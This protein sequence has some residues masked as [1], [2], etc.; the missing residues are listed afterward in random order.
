MQPVNCML[1]DYMKQ[2]IEELATRGMDADI[3]ASIA[4]AEYAGLEY[5]QLTSATRN[6]LPD[7][8]FVFSKER[9][10]PIHD[11]AHAAN[12][13]A[14]AAGTK[15]HAAVMKAVCKKYPDMPAC[16][17][18]HDDSDAMWI[19]VFKTGTHTASNGTVKTYSHEDIAEIADL[20]NAQTEHK[21]PL[22]FGH[23]ATDDPAHG[24]I[25]TLKV[26]GNKLYAFCDQ[27]SQYA[28]DST[29]SGAYKFVSIALYPNKLL[30]HVGLLGATPPAVKGLVPVA[31]SATEEFEELETAFAGW[32]T[33]EYRVPAIGRLFSSI[34]DFFIEKFGLDTANKILDKNSINSLM[35]SATETYI[36]DEPQSKYSDSQEDH[37]TPEEKKALDDRLAKIETQVAAFGEAAKGITALAETVT[38]LDSSVKKFSDTA[39]AL[40]A[41]VTTL[42]VA[43]D[44]D[45]VAEFA[46]F[47]ESMVKEGKILAAEKQGLVDQYSELLTLEKGVTFADKQLPPSAK[48]KAGIEARPVINQRQPRFAS[49]DSA[50]QKDS[51]GNAL[52]ATYSEVMDQVDP[53][54]LDLDAQIRAYMEEKK[55]SYEVASQHFMQ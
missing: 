45:R 38:K 51:K 16:K 8:A 7:S 2:R 47:A 34:R 14:R 25:Q 48:F 31:F 13:L 53:A 21:A 37:M 10:F 27:V 12:A 28:K 46:S 43:K 11:K 33:D 22:V 49:K 36:P 52:P 6:A 30:R 4:Y 50:A 5:K 23:P 24:W 18:E 9:R 55:V 41:D 26:I 40:A 29:K 32:A 3:A 15:D 17:T 54:S 1:S 20:Y 35:K 42:K 39:T 19:E 44:A